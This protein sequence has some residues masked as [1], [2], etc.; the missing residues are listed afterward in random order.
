M[1]AFPFAYYLNFSVWILVEELFLMWSLPR[2]EEWLLRLALGL[3]AFFAVGYGAV[4]LVNAL[5]VP[6]LVAYMPLFLLS[7]LLS[8]VLW[9][10]ALDA[11]WRQVFF[12]CV[13]AYAVQHITYSLGSVLGNGLNAAGLTWVTSSAAYTYF[14]RYAIYVFS[15]WL[16]YRLFVKNYRALGNLGRG[17]FRAT[18]LCL[19]ILFVSIVLS[20]LCDAVIP[21]EGAYVCRIYAT[22]SCALAL[23]L[24]FG[25]FANDRA[26]AEVQRL[27]GMLRSQE[28]QRALAQ[29]TVDAI[30]RKCHDLKYQL[31]ALAASS[32]GAGVAEVIGDLREQVD[33]F[34]SI[35]KTG[36]Q[37]LDLVLTE[38]ALLCQRDKIALSCMVDGSALD[39]I[40]A[41]D[42]YALFGNILDNAIEAARKLPEECRSITLKVAR[43]GKM[44]SVSQSNSFAGELEFKDGLPAHTS[45]ADA[46]N[47]GFGTRSIRYIVELCGGEVRMR[48]EKGVFELDAIFSPRG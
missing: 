42:L 45:K 16:F 9:H 30:N 24:Q 1:E 10:F 39:F 38:K 41:G 14:N 19:V 5:A 22:V 3:A 34:D 33:V 11:R 17:E 48:A 25:L 28:R 13:S 47:H 46:A 2:K 23:A 29:E 43:Q 31:G 4:A 8:I 32:D 21:S 20:F 7:F 44:V 27:D 18:A 40:S 37:T 15:G 12:L 6:Y 26:E 35:Y 36:N